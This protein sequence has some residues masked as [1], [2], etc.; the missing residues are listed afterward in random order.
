MSPSRAAEPIDAALLRGWPLPQ[1]GGGD[2]NERGS[3]FVVAGAP[4]MPG[5]AILCGTAVVDA[6]ARRFNAVVALKGEQTYIAAPD[7]SLYRNDR[8]D[9]GLATSGSGDVLAGIVGGLH[10][11]A[12][13]RVAQR[14]GLGFLARELPAE[15]PS[16]LR[17]LTE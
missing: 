1:P 3:A 14:I 13:G 12:G 11:R 6:A 10:A 16:L 4:Q 5:A 17:E 9:V 15:I 8:G 2:K 7:G